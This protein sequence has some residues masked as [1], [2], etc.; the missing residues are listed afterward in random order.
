MTAEEGIPPC[1]A[2]QGRP[3]RPN[4]RPAERWALALALE[5]RRQPIHT[6]LPRRRGSAGAVELAVGRELHVDV[7]QGCDLL[8]AEQLVALGGEGRAHARL[9]LAQRALQGGLE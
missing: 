3:C 4:R 2:C 6:T 1:R 5:P 9:R 8:E 7:A